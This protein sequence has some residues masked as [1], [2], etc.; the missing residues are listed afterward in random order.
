MR[1]GLMWGGRGGTRPQINHIPTCT[2]H[3][4]LHLSVAVSVVSDGAAGCTALCTTNDG[5]DAA[6]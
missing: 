3:V 6:L 2:S 4:S 5:G 1:L